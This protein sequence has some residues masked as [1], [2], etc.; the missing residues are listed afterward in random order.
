MRIRF[1]GLLAASCLA[2]SCS[3][4]GGRAASAGSADDATGGAETGD[5]GPTE[6]PGE[7][8]PEQ[9]FE[10]RVVDD[11]P[12]P[13][14]LEMD[15]DE[16]AELFGATAHDVLLLELD[17]APLLTN[18]LEK[19][20]F[21]CGDSWGLDDP[22]PK[23]DCSLTPLGQTFQGT[24]GTW[25]T[26]AEYSMVRLLT[27][28]PANVVVDGTSSESL[29]NL[30]DALNVGGGYSQI[31]AEALGIPRTAPVVSTP[32]MVAA[33]KEHFVAS[34]PAT[35]DDGNMRF[36]LADALSNLDTMTGRYGPQD[37][38]PGVI[39]P[40]FPVHGEVFTD[41]FQM[42]AVAESNLRVVDGID[43]DQGKGYMTVIVDETGP[44]YDDA[45][46]FDFLDPERFRLDGI[47][48]NLTVDLRFK[49]YEDPA[50]IWSCTGDPP[51][52]ANEPG[53]P[54]SAG[55][56]WA[57][58]P[59]FIEYNLASAARNRYIDRTFYGS[60]ALGAAKVR[61]GQDGNPPGW[62]QYEVTFGLGNPPDD[63]WLWETVLEVGQVALHQTPY[64]TFA[65]GQANVA[66]TM[67]DIPVGL[68]GSQAA[69]AVRPFLHAQSATLSEFL[70]GDY[71]KNNDRLDFFYQRASDGELYLFFVASSDLREDEPYEYVRP[72]FFRTSR[73]EPAEKVSSTTIV[74][75]TDTEHEKLHVPAGERVVYYEDDG[76]MVYRVRIERAEGHS[77][78]TVAIAARL[79]SG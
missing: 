45:L 77:A 50:F 70:L 23:H 21:A 62:I 39:D 55:S 47:R 60:Y 20:K 73:L 75:L 25:Q 72:G 31:L 34:H 19:I 6:E 35:T 5:E 69:E 43:G 33:F 53:N 66:F 30:A 36:T 79:G 28:T 15:R 51:C 58:D 27:M 46:E 8:G 10:L 26:S 38:H 78:A 17:T 12:P 7:F 42:R 63:Q 74:G 52:Q 44:T 57:V 37:G 18:T 9:T 64:A 2:L 3:G 71:K 49:L 41:D 40:T 76:G 22:D 48:E 56:V 1:H 4:S 32:A 61:I 68:T 13:L 29:R 24:D 67:E 59:W 65:E 11:P 16:V 54:V 14:V